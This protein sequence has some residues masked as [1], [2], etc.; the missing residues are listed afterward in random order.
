MDY[1]DFEIEISSTGKRGGYRVRAS[2]AGR[3]LESVRPNSK[4]RSEAPELGEMLFRALFVRTVRET[5]E[6]LLAWLDEKRAKDSR[7]GLRL[8]MYFGK[9]GTAVAGESSEMQGDLVRFASLPWERLFD[10]ARRSHLALQEGNS[11]V[12][13]FE[14]AALEGEMTV[15]GPVR[16]LLVSCGPSDLHPLNLTLEAQ[17]IEERLA[18]SGILEVD[19]LEDPSFEEVTDCLRAKEFHLFHFLGHGGFDEE[20]GVGHLCFVKG[21]LAERR[22]ARD[23]AQ[24]LGGFKSL[25]LVVLNACK[26]GKV[27]SASG[28]SPFGGVAIE[29]LASGIPAVVAMQGAI[30]DPAA[31]AFADRFYRALRSTGR[32]EPA[33]TQARMAIE[34]AQSDGAGPFEWSYPALYQRPREGRLFEVTAAK[35]DPTG[36]ESRPVRLGIGSFGGWGKGREDQLDW[37][38]DL[39]SSFHRRF[40]RDGEL[41]NGTVF[42][43]L[44]RFL[45]EHLD[46]RK[47]LHLFLR[48]H[49]SL[50]FLAGYLIDARAGIDLTLEQARQ[51]LTEQWRSDDPYLPDG[52]LWQ[53]DETREIGP[54]ATD[55]VL[56][57]SVSDSAI[58]GAQAYITENHLSVRRVHHATITGGAFQG[59]VTNGGH[60]TLLVQRLRQEIQ[61]RDGRPLR[62]TL[63]VFLACPI[64]FAFLL[65]QVSGPLGRLQL[66]EWDFHRLKS[67]RYEPSIVLDPLELAGLK[68]RHGGAQV[69]F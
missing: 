54:E 45:S 40:L 47:P 29:L 4:V 55:E 22:S 33:L 28:V 41:W 37:P 19:H 36:S 60:A 6:R 23:V 64:S 59:S 14:V 31:I 69:P 51:N 38:L 53:F 21:G 49:L 12:R 11:L 25:R 26:G 46:E 68:L 43:D 65:G 42:G 15:S 2:G 63:H 20:T 13:T 67:N 52:P 18:G 48:T 39:S 3:R 5:Y 35:E 8:R 32:I 34:D 44:S 9:V 62:G 1:Q 24:R 56:V 16:V 66:Y 50:G 30:S 17:K 57:V 10:P 7:K 58:R 61:A 27:A